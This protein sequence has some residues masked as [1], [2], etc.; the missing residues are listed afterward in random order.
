[1][2]L[3]IQ[4]RRG[5]ASQWSSSNPTLAQGEPGYETDTGLMKYGDG[6]TAWNSL[7][8]FMSPTPFMYVQSSQP[9]M[10]VGDLWLDTTATI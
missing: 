3:Q 4:V 7:A 10:V 5:T 2:A 6:T 1:M 9:T 8:Y